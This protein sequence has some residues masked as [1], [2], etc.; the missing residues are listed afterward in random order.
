MVFLAGTDEIDEPILTDI[1]TMIVTIMTENFEGKLLES[2]FLNSENYAKFQ[3]LLDEVIPQGIL[4]T[5]DYDVVVKMSKL[6]HI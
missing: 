3:L 1:L 5:T 2:S 4:E 6:K